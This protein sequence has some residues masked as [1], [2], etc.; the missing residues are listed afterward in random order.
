MERN[1]ASRKQCGAAAS[2]LLEKIE[3]NTGSGRLCPPGHAGALHSLASPRQAGCAAFPGP[4]DGATLSTPVLPCCSC[5]CDFPRSIERNRSKEYMAD[6]ASV[7]RIPTALAAVTG[8]RKITTDR[9]V[10]SALLAH[11]AMCVVSGEP[12]LRST[13]GSAAG[14]CAVCQGVQVAVR[15]LPRCRRIRGAHAADCWAPWRVP[16]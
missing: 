6:P 12:C 9:A 4:T 3:T 8:F 10:W 7:S 5:S 15:A 1:R 13:C 11:A 14:L 2:P 16:T